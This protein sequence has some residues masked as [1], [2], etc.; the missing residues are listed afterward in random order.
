[1]I[2]NRV[3]QFLRRKNI[4]F[5]VQRYLIDGL[6]AMALGLFGTLI[7]GVILDTLGSQLGLPSLIRMGE[8][9][10]DMM[11]PGIAVAVAH[12]FGAPPLVLF[13]AVV[14][15]YAGA[16]GGPVGAWVSAVVATE[17]GKMVAQETRLDIIVTPS[18][19][20]ISGVGAAE[21][22]GPPIAAFMTGLGQF[23]MWAT[24]LHPLPMG[25]IVAVVMGWAL[26]APISSAALA[27]ALD[28]SGIAAGAALAGCCA[29]MIGFAV[30]SYPDNGVG[31]LVSQGLGT[32]MLQIPNVVR[33]PII[34]IPVTVA[35]MVAGPLATL[36][37]RMDSTEW[38]AGMGTSGLVGQFATVTA[39]GWSAGVLLS[40]AVLHFI[41]PAVISGIAA[42]YMR[43]SGRIAPGDMKI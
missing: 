8:F 39:M 3:K 22:V 17:L 23:I 37:F 43:L 40:M 2:G 32:S 35:S 13:A 31:G 42:K 9:A 41:L 29:H 33:R 16:A 10:Q 25:I 15:G 20:V 12:A 34:G 11:G 5:T 24:E 36:V 28:L 19:V 6:G 21:F 27:V 38:G 30:A 14:A 7:I 4:E 18:V 26:T 1:M